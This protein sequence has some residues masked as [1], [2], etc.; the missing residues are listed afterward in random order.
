MPDMKDYMAEVEYEIWPIR[1]VGGQQ[2]GSYQCGVRGTHPLGIIASCHTERSQ[3]KNKQVVE[4][5]IEW[6]LSKVLNFKE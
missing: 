4:E 2:V 1:A 5:M 3:H 6:A